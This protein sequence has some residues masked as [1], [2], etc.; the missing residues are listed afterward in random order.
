[1]VVDAATDRPIFGRG[2]TVLT[3]D[4]LFSALVYLTNLTYR[5]QSVEW[6]DDCK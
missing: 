3:T 1:M 5:L 6:Q 4:P 2:K